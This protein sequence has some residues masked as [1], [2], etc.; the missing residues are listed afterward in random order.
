MDSEYCIGSS[1]GTL[2]N[3]G[4]QQHLSVV[5]KCDFINYVY[6]KVNK[7]VERD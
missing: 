4:T 7:C 2:V 5:S 6:R 1:V 3:S